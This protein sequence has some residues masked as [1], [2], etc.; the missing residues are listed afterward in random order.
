MPSREHHGDILQ[1][2][3]DLWRVPLVMC[4]ATLLCFLLTVRV[5]WAA[6]QRRLT[7]TFARLAEHITQPSL[8]DALLEQV[9]AVWEATAGDSLVKLDRT[10]VEAAS[11]RAR[12]ALGER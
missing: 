4:L 2:R 7:Y 9:E 3:P 6:A 11:R 8:R 5:D 12:E 1:L 10:D